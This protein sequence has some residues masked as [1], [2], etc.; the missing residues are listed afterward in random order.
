MPNTHASSGRDTSRVSQMSSNI[1]DPPRARKDTVLNVVEASIRASQRRLQAFPTCRSL[2][3]E[4]TDHYSSW[5]HD[6]E[7]YDLLNECRQ[8]LYTH[9]A[10]SGLA[11]TFL[12]ILVSTLMHCSM[13]IEDSPHEPE[14]EHDKGRLSPSLSPLANARLS[15]PILPKATNLSLTSQEAQW[16]LRE[17]RPLLKDE[18]A[19]KA[20]LSYPRMAQE[21]GQAPLASSAMDVTASKQL[22]EDAPEGIKHALPGVIKKNASYH[23]ARDPL[24]RSQMARIRADTVLPKM[25]VPCDVQAAQLSS[26]NKTDETSIPR[27]LLIQECNGG[28][29]LTAVQRPGACLQIGVGSARCAPVDSP[30][31]Q[32]GDTIFNDETTTRKKSC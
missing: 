15:D 6:E 25:G 20:L 21:I 29:A 3:D 16:A 18:R 13:R 5:L 4:F 14:D 1:K 23:D 12:D 26:Q 17:D 11:R 30:P 2:E 10:C 8:A 19:I 28:W 24:E 9:Q 27:D 31:V 7:Y 32:G 22:D